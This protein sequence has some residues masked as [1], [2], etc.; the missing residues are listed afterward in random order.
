MTIRLLLLLLLSFALLLRS[1]LLPF[2]TQNHF[3]N[4]LRVFDWKQGIARVSRF[5][6]SWSL[7]F[8]ISMGFCLLCNSMC[9]DS[10]DF[11]LYD[12]EWIFCTQIK[13]ERKALKLFGWWK[14]DILPLFLVFFSLTSLTQTISHF[15]LL[16]KIVFVLQIPQSKW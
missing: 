9:L 14:E 5:T 8:R 11:F 7:N 2:R 16:C 15:H 1:S 10:L 13:P 12:F 4:I 6:C 3:A